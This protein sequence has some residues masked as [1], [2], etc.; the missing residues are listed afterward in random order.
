MTTLLYYYY[1]LTDIKIGTMI[2]FTIYYTLLEIDLFISIYT[3]VLIVG[4]DTNKNI[5]SVNGGSFGI[6]HTLYTALPCMVSMT[7]VSWI[8]F[9]PFKL[10]IQSISMILLWIELKRRHD[11]L[12][13][14]FEHILW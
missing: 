11:R 3:S 1:T 8:R 6:G 10:F 7:M 5:I 9:V 4:A 13:V 2:L 12:Q 14:S